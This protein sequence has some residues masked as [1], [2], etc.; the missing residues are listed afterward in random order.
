MW[1]TSEGFQET[2]ITAPSYS[3]ISS[4]TTHFL[5][6]GNV[7]HYLWPRST[8]RLAQ[9]LPTVQPLNRPC[10]QGGAGPVHVN[11]KA[12]VF[13]FSP[14]FKWIHTGPGM[15]KKTFPASKGVISLFA[16]W[17][18]TPRCRSACPVTPLRYA[19]LGVKWRLSADRW[20]C[21]KA[22]VDAALEPATNGSD[23]MKYA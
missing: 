18:R 2:Q 14:P 6:V 23:D 17:T 16:A 9:T 21:L 1:K 4:N 11:I 8:L 19:E 5:A 10:T 12:V 13:F 7:C 20:Q 15:T 3:H 22:R